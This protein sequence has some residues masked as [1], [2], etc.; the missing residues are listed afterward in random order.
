MLVWPLNRFGR[1]KKPSEL[2]PHD[3]DRIALDELRKEQIRH[4][5]VTVGL[6]Y[7]EVQ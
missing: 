2:H 3:S 4:S 1:L 5:R 6:G 7:P